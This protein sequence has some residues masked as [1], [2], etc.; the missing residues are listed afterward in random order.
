MLVRMA[1]KATSKK[2]EVALKTSD[3]LAPEESR[4]L[5]SFLVDDLWVSLD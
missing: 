3:S 4:H 5:G 2:E 1:I